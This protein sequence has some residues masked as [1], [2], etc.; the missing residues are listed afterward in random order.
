MQRNLSLVSDE[1]RSAFYLD[2]PSFCTMKDPRVKKYVNAKNVKNQIKWPKLIELYNKLFD[3]DFENAHDAMAD[4]LAT[5]EC[6][7][8]L[9]SLE[10][11]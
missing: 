4:I 7:F 2:T 8:K 10:I 3:K 5:R 11:I 1:A 9:R 6:Y